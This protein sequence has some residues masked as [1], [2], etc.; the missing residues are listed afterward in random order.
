[1]VR[2]TPHKEDK[3]DTSSVEAPMAQAL[4]A[5]PRSK[6]LDN[7]LVDDDLDLLSFKVAESE[8][9]CRM[10]SRLQRCCPN[11]GKLDYP[12]WDSGHEDVEGGLGASLWLACTWT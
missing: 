1:M 2:T 11:S 3:V 6:A 12:V 10:S 4:V 8:I 9:I 5:R 7:N